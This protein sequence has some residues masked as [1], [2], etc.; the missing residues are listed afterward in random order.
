[1]H[2]GMLLKV[3]EKLLLSSEINFNLSMI[4]YRNI[5][6]ISWHHQG[7]KEVL[8]ATLWQDSINTPIVYVVIR[9]KGLM[10]K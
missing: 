4:L 8:A 7:R 1:M 9:A 2:F 10:P 5:F 3:E 6:D